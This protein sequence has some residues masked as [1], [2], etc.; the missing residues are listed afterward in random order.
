MRTLFN[1]EEVAKLMVY[2]TEQQRL[3]ELAKLAC[4]EAPVNSLP[5]PTVSVN[6]L[7]ATMPEKAKA[8]KHY[9]LIL[10]V[11]KESKEGETLRVI[12]RLV[13]YKV[14]VTL[15]H[16]NNCLWFGIGRGEIRTDGNKYFFV[17]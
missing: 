17:K 7:S 9:G 1:F 5:V 13:T 3:A 16:V 8:P 4:K 11:L 12:Y 6:A 14:S 2:A 10:K 15:E